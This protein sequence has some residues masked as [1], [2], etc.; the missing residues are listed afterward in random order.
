M[1]HLQRRHLPIQIDRVDDRIQR[2]TREISSTCGHLKRNR[3]RQSKRNRRPIPRATV[4]IYYIAACDTDRVCRS[5]C[6]ISGYGNI[7]GR[8]ITISWA[9]RRYG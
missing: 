4:D 2:D 5:Q 7:K 8:G 6:R 1:G 9:N 3:P